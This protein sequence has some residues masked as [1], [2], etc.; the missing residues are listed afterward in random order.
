MLQMAIGSKSSEPWPNGHAIGR[1]SIKGV[2]EV[3]G[4]WFG[5]EVS[6]PLPSLHQ[7]AQELFYQ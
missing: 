6:R 1:L 4:N 5:A 2:E 3:V 7:L